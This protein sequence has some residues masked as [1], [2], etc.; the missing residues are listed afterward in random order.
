MGMPLQSRVA[1]EITRIINRLN[2]SVSRVLDGRVDRFQL[3]D[4]ELVSTYTDGKSETF[5]LLFPQQIHKDLCKIH[6]RLRE[7][8]HAVN[9]PYLLMGTSFDIVLGIDR[10]RNRNRLLSELHQVVGVLE[11]KA[12]GALALLNFYLG[13]SRSLLQRCLG[14]FHRWMWA[15]RDSE[16][17]GKLCKDILF[18]L[19]GHNF[20]MALEDVVIAAKIV[21]TEEIRF[22]SKYDMAMAYDFDFRDDEASTAGEITQE[23]F[24]GVSTLECPPSP[25]SGLSLVENLPVDKRLYVHHYLAQVQ[26][27][28]TLNTNH[29][30]GQWDP[31]S[32]AKQLSTGFVEPIPDATIMEPVDSY[33]H[34][35]LNNYTRQPAFSYKSSREILRRYL[36]ENP[37]LPPTTA[38]PT[39]VQEVGAGSHWRN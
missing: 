18:F 11:W 15:R 22:R 7:V 39:V 31:Q 36:S 4:T 8:Q 16:K 24:P 25:T 20:T 5:R 17:A 12:A 30:L 9:N 28:P 1:V 2:N 14:G 3:A 26:P 21:E 29:P 35:H 27:P 33:S 13:I 38:T 32:L 10:S 6:R 37:A 19:H 23:D 34:P